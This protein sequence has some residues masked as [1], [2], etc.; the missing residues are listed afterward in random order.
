MAGQLVEGLPASRR[1]L[2]RPAL[3]I[4]GMAILAAALLVLPGRTIATRGLEDLFHILDGANR[5]LW[6]QVPG[7][8]FITSL[9]PLVHYL[10]AFGQWIGGWG[11]AMPV[12][13]GL[14]LLVF[15]PIMAHVLASRLHPVLALLMAAFL[16][17]VLAA[18]MNLG[19]PMTALS[20]AQYHNRIG[21]VALALLLVMVLPPL[22]VGTG[23]RDVAAAAIL[24]F[25]MVYVRLT[26][27]LAPL[28]FLVFMLADRRQRG[29]AALA[30]VGLA[31]SALAMELIW[32]GTAGYLQATGMA[33]GA[34]G[35]L[36]G[37]WGDIIDHILVSFTDYVLLGLIAGISLWRRWSVGYALF[38]ALCA[39]GGFWIINHN[40]QRW[41]ILALHA[42]AV[43]AAERIL[44]EGDGPKPPVWGN[45]A[46]AT[47]FFFVMVLPT[48]LH[49]G[50]ALGLHASA[51]VT[52][53]GRPMPIAGMEDLRLA[54]LWTGGDFGGGNR[55]LATVEDGI[56]ALADLQPAPESIAVLGAADPFSA[57]LDL[58]PAPGMM[59]IMRWLNTMGPAHHPQAARIF[60]GADVVLVRKTGTN[61]VHDIYLPFLDREFT[62]LPET[63]FWQIYRRPVPAALP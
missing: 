11:A 3:P 62:R 52:G 53:A 40:E 32:G 42:A 34:G 6:G 7:R 38:F 26:Y 45:A 21:W 54:D 5:V 39:I 8:D 55:Y 57:A 28:A 14:V 48:I 24:A 23:W 41:G 43:V 30:L 9:G 47:L 10:P 33:F 35:V 12:A 25:A 27:G 44:R 63:E 61:P 46:G 50:I 49:N 37:S 56:S 16:V 4:L 18:P 1:L 13:M 29:W 51:A 59:P 58:R 20:F 60:A 19:E 2:A 15:A 36:R 17:L 22:R 31:V